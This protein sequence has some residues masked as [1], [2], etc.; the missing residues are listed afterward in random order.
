M[1]LSKRWLREE[2]NHYLLYENL[3]VLHLN[4][5]ET[6]SPKNALCKVWFKLA[7][8]FWRR[9]FLFNSSVYFRYFTIISPMKRAEPFIWTNLNSLHPRMPCAKLVEISPAVLEKIFRFCQCIIIYPRKKVESFIW[10]NL[11]PYH[12]RML[13]ANFGWN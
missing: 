13:W 2:I 11:S 6:P 12:S 3:M 4:K 7:Q 9:R 5:L 1:I 10:T 8:W